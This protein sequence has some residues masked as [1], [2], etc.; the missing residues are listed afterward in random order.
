MIKNQTV[1]SDTQMLFSLHK[2]SSI[3]LNKPLQV[4]FSPS[5][6]SSN[7]ATTSNKATASIV[8]TYNHDRLHFTPAFLLP[9]D[10]V[11][12][13]SLRNFTWKTAASKS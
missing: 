9:I 3:S 4:D 8:P 11:A 10:T 7:L 6:P 13:P 12:L 5:V 1:N 2:L